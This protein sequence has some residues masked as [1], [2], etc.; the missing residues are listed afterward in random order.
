[1][2]EYN[3]NRLSNVKFNKNSKV[4]LTAFSMYNSFFNISRSLYNNNTIIYSHYA[5]WPE[6]DGYRDYAFTIDDGFY[7]C[8][9]MNAFI[10]YKM[11]QNNLHCITT[12]T[13]ENFYFFNMSVNLTKYANTL[14]FYVIENVGNLLT[15]PSGAIW[16]FPSGTKKTCKISFSN[17][18][19]WGFQNNI[20]YGDNLNDFSIDSEFTPKINKVTSLIIGLNL[21]DN[22]YSNPN[23][24]VQCIPIS[25]SYGK[26]ITPQIN[27][28]Y[29]KIYDTTYNN[30]QIYLHDQHYNRL[31]ILDTEVVIQ[32]SI[33]D[34]I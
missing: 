28:L 3:F 7:S 33:I 11:V 16:G 21:I 2:F 5:N 19:L 15:I 30:I 24:I 8:E 31:P 25:A 22:N 12:S 27:P 29:S 13:S 10:Q 9:Q 26:L 32:L 20:T 18:D 34:E 6:G 14:D 17:G 1:M 4:A 23:N